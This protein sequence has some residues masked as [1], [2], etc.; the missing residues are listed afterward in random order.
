MTS[1]QR[2]WPLTVIS[3]AEKRQFVASPMLNTIRRNR[4]VKNLFTPVKY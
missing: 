3:S 1:I 2:L 4:Y